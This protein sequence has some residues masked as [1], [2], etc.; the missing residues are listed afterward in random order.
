MALKASLVVAL[1]TPLAAFAQAP[2]VDTQAATGGP[3][4]ASV[5]AF[6]AGVAFDLGQDG[7]PD[8]VRA[9]EEYAIAASAGMPEAE[10]NLAVMLDSGIGV[11]I[12]RKVAALWYARAA[13]HGFGR[14]AFDLAGLCARGD[15]I[16]ADPVLAARWFRLAADDG[17]KAAARPVTDPS[18]G[19]VALV[20]PE[21]DPVQVD[22]V[23]RAGGAIPVEVVWTVPSMPRDG[24]FFLEVASVA[25]D[26]GHH[27]IVWREVPV[28]AA[29][30]DLPPGSGHY[31]WRVFLTS[32]ATGHY[33]S[34]EWRGFA[35]GA[36]R[37]AGGDGPA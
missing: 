22:A 1:L 10:F 24:D 6:D 17:I 12:D 28:A 21:P 32:P 26:G 18:A 16:P 3:S 19:A 35:A 31:A 7:E 33:V 5:Q 8:P 13:A 14:A 20:P 15:G 25:P 27:D 4:A 34:T 37:N 29:L 2:P 23:G 9:R 36:G 30:V 11:D